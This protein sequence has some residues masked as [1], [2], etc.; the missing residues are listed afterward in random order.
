MRDGRG[1]EEEGKGKWGFS[2]EPSHKWLGYFQEK[3]DGDGG[4]VL[5]VKIGELTV[6][7]PF[8]LTIVYL[9]V[10]QLP[11]M[12]PGFVPLVGPKDHKS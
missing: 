7:D 6:S 11:I 5:A 12:S 4:C 2:L 10:H 8:Y 9:S 1:G 3:A